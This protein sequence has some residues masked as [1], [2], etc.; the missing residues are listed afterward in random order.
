MQCED[1]KADDDDNDYNSSFFVNLEKKYFT[2]M[3]Y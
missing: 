3:D 2:V 1:L